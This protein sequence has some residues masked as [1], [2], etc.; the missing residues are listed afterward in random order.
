[1]QNPAP[2]LLSSKIPV[3]LSVS[4]RS[5]DLGQ[6]LLDAMK[7]AK[8][9][10][11]VDPLQAEEDYEYYDYAEAGKPAAA[12]A[13]HGGGHTQHHH[14]AK[15]GRQD[16]HGGN[17]LSTNYQPPAHH[18]RVAG[19]PHQNWYGQYNHMLPRTNMIGSYG[20]GY[21]KKH[22]GGCKCSKKDDDGINPGLLGV[23]AVAGAALVNAVAAAAAG[24]GRKRR[25]R[26]ADMAMD[27][28][29]MTEMMDVVQSGRFLDGG[30]KSKIVL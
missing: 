17:T 12:K 24:T 20:G 30:T 11:K 8:I 21:G 27:A 9:M 5:P 16:D 6:T 3:E 10:N 15:A 1:M 22:K 19:G 28:N 7:A 18:Q 26:E 2:H 23:L 25:R 29:P 13:N 4:V 14:L